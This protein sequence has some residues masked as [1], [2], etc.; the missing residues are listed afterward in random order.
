MIRVIAAFLLLLAF[1]AGP[2]NAPP[3]HALLD[4]PTSKAYQ[5]AMTASTLGRHQEAESLARTWSRARTPEG[6]VL[7]AVVSL[8]RFADLHDLPALE[9]SRTSLDRARALLEGAASPH[10]RFLLALTYSQDAFLAG[11][12]GRNLSSALA[13]RK[14]ANLCQDLLSEGFDSP[15]LRGIVGGYLFWKAQAL[16]PMRFAMGGD[17]RDK[18][19][20][21]T[22]SAAAVPGPFQEAYRT[23]LMWIHFERGE[24]DKGLALARAG[25]TACPGN[26][27]YKQAEGDML[28]RS[29]LF[30]PALESYRLSWTQYAGLEAIPANRMA[31]AGNLA[32][33]HLSMGRADSARAWLDT[34]DA[35]R[36]LKTRRWLP[37]SLVHD[38]IPV[39]KRLAWP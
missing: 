2:S 15:D 36:Y 22:Q 38:L 11:L 37:P 26:R 4:G 39:R 14:A 18:G 30:P 25:L 23:S 32:K 28:Y 10:E 20:L 31:A 24:F 35:P 9:R 12:E 1:P 27:L 19:L 17:T 21:W 33:I 8:S 6:L 16:G 13:G 29:G 34:L 7:Q 5:E 3:A